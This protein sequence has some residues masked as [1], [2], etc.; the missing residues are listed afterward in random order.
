MIHNLIIN[1]PQG[2]LEVQYYSAPGGILIKYVY[3]EWLSKHIE[4]GGSIWESLARNNTIKDMLVII[5]HGGKG[6]DLK[7]L[8]KS[9]YSIVLLNVI[10]DY[11]K[12]NILAF[13]N[14]KYIFLRIC[15]GGN[16]YDNESTFLKNQNHTSNLIGSLSDYLASATK[17]IIVASTGAMIVDEIK[18]SKPNNDILE[19]TQQD[20]LF[21]HA[22][23]VVSYI[24]KD[25]KLTTKFYKNSDSLLI[26]NQELLAKLLEFHLTSKNNNFQARINFVNQMIYTVYFTCA[27]T[28]IMMAISEN[29]TI[30]NKRLFSYLSIMNLIAIPFRITSKY[31]AKYLYKVRVSKAENEHF[32]SNQNILLLTNYIKRINNNR[33]H[34]I[35][36]EKNT[37]CIINI[38]FLAENNNQ[39]KLNNTNII[40]AEINKF[41]NLEGII[42]NRNKHELLKYTNNNF[43]RRKLTNS[44]T[45]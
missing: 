29:N 7:Y 17:K 41:R 36:I 12:N 26:D 23:L 43:H 16:N 1:L 32:F 6:G 10:K 35:D 11:Y 3:I 13:N 15:Y 2:N 31:I 22:G 38:D 34:I 25:N 27:I 9:L 20:N 21:L 45:F 24:N 44:I 4:V 5:S 40:S 14:L 8:N 18:I 19:S 37:D 33:E 28:S 39:I 30:N 42:E